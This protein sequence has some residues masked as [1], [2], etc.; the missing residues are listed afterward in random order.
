MSEDMISLRCKYCGAPLE[1]DDVK[2]DSAYVTCGSCGTTQQRVDARAY[3]DQLTGQVIS[4]LNKAI[5]GG[6][7][8]AASSSVDAVAR[9]NIYI[10]NIQPKVD[11]EFG[12]YKFGLISMISKVLMVMPFTTSDSVN[13]THTSTQIFEFGAKLKGVAPLAVSD[14]TAASLGEA[15][16]V[17]DAY[18]VLINN[19]A[20]LKKDEPGRYILMANNFTTAADDLKNV[21]GYEPAAL[22]F[23]GLALLCNG[24][25]NLCN[26]NAAE[27]YGNFE[28]GVAKLKEAVTSLKGNMKVPVIAP[29]LGVETKMGETLAELASYVNSMGGSKEVFDAIQKLSAYRYPTVGEWGYL[30]QAATRMEEIL[31]TMG[32]AAKARSGTG[33]IVTAPGD[34]DILVPFWHI[35]LNYS[36][37]TGSLWKKKSVTVTEHLL[38]AADFPIDE[39]CLRNPRE[40]VTDVFANAGNAKFFDKLSGNQASLSNS[41]GIDPLVESASATGTSGRAVVVPLSTEKEGEK[42]AEMYVKNAASSSQKQ[43]KLSNPDVMG[44]VYIPFTRAGDRVTGGPSL[45]PERT[46]RMDLSNMVV[47]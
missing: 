7:N 26:G 8:M 27:A 35:K 28:A 34:G 11:A 47:L 30:L 2:G 17:T 4:W 22:R 12:N 6:M 37:E 39:G 45:V 21:K 24:C 33:T 42:L 18:A 9:H 15:S 46:K 32:D 41:S 44:L 29:A 10:T 38:V 40:A 36:F 25:E 1:A 3:L 14:E 19:T 5:P 13:P 16:G 23:N 20:L 31:D 43:L